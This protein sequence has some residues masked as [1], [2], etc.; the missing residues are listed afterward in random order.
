MKKCWIEIDI[1]VFFLPAF[2]PSLGK[3]GTLA[4]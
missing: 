4:A 1:K 2:R 3:T